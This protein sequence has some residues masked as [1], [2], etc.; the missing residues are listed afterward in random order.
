MRQYSIN[1]P[2]LAATECRTPALGEKDRVSFVCLSRL[3]HLSTTGREWPNDSTADN[4]I[5]QETQPSP[6]KRATRLEVSQA[7]QS[8]RYFRYR[9]Y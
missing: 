6:T 9:S 4:Y 3:P 1:T 5:K 2:S 7:H 8:I